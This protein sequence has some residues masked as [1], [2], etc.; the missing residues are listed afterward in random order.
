LNGQLYHVCCIAA[1]AK[2]ALKNKTSLKYKPLKYENRIEFQFLSKR[3]LIGIKPYKA[4]NV[5]DWFDFCIEKKL[6]DIIVLVPA[7]YKERGVLGFSNTTQGSLVCFFK[8]KVTYFIPNWEFD[9]VQKVWN[10]LYIEQKWEKAPLSKPCFDN[11]YKSLKIALT[12]IKELAYKIDCDD[13]AATFQQS[14]DMLSGS[15]DYTGNLPLPEIPLNNLNL[16][17]AASIADVFGAM[18]S[19][20]DT[21][22]YLAPEKGLDKEYEVLSNE[23]LKQI[24]LIVFKKRVCI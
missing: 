3:N 22:P 13:F 20:N 6:Q 24:R 14:L 21:P 11:N 2:N 9:S 1:A 12:K 15:E 17:Y 23:L 18:G 4:A 8:E 7:A 5:E 10:I 19:W 16:F